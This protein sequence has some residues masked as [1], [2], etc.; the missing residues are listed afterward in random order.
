MPS[1]AAHR[2]ET[3]LTMLDY[4]VYVRPALRFGNRGRRRLARQQGVQ[5]TSLSVARASHVALADMQT[6]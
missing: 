3:L 1:A 5:A 4:R 2:S 6:C